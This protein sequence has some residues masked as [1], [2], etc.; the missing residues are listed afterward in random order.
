MASMKHYEFYKIMCHVRRGNLVLKHRR[1]N[2]GRE[3]TG[4]RKGDSGVR[5]GR[6]TRRLSSP[7]SKAKVQEVS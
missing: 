6:G 5:E 3:Q 4:Y 1:K 2:R 7:Q